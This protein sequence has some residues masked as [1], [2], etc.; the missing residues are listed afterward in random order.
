MPPDRRPAG[1]PSDIDQSGVR[2][3]GLIHARFLLTHGPNLGLEQMF[4]KWANCHFPECPRTF[5]EGRRCLP[6]GPSEEVGESVVRMFCPNCREVYTSDDPI[7]DTIDGAYFGPAWVHL[8]VQ[9]YEQKVI[10]KGD[11]K[12]PPVKLFGF[13]IETDCS[14]DCANER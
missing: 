6:F 1:W 10:P 13:R 7:S 8:F 2:L 4:R 11:V 3:Y 9:E 12:H 14:D 5:C